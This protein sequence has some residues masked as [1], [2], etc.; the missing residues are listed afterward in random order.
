MLTLGI[1]IFS[2]FFGAGNVIF[3]LALGAQSAQHFTISF[4]GLILTSIGAPL[5]GLYGA[6]LY[7][8]NLR[9][10]FRPLGPWL[11]V[12]MILVLVI[13]LGP[14]G[15]M[16]RCLSLTYSALIPLFP[17]LS[18]PLFT[19]LSVFV[20]LTLVFKRKYLL[21][22]LGKFLSPL[23]LS[24]I[25]AITIIGI[26]NFESGSYTDFTRTQALYRGIHEGYQTMDLLAAILFSITI[27]RIIKDKCGN[28]IYQKCIQ[29][30][31]IA[32]VLLAIIYIALGLAAKANASLLL[33]VS[34]DH[35]LGT[36]SFELLGPR[37]GILANIT[38]ALACFTTIISLGVAA[39]DA[40]WQTFNSI[41]W[42][43]EREKEFYIIGSMAITLTTVIFAN[44]GFD[45]ISKVISPIVSICYPAIITLTVCNILHKKW[46]FKNFKTPTLSVLGLTI[47]TRIFL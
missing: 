13:A 19:M 2:M 1:A 3:P 44:V 24:M 10:F 47:L 7:E 9:E 16:P 35:L 41:S 17:N 23:L 30:S 20:I 22:V 43:K 28:N 45:N 12:G 32:G 5:L 21:P 15:A 25:L 40:L 34:H 36:L 6:L 37:W 26:A 14:F 42:L 38:I 31:L 4:I 29:S 39:V 11:S 33:N 18:L 8:G 46:G 27:W